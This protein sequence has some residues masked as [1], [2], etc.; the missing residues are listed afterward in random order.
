MATSSDKH[1]KPFQLG[2]TGKMIKSTDPSRLIIDRD[3]APPI[4]DNF[5][6]LKNIRYTDNG[7]KGIKGMTKINSTISNPTYFKARNIHHFSKASPS[8]SHLLVQSFNTGLNASKVLKNDTP[9]PNTG[10]FDATELHTDAGGASKGRF[11]T[12]QSGR[13]AYCNSAETMIWG[14]DKSRLSN[15]TIFDPDGSFKYDYTEKIQNTLRDPDNVASVFTTAGGDDANAVLLLHCNGADGGTIFTDDGATGHTVTAVGNA[16]TAT[17]LKKFNTAAMELNGT[18]DWCVIPDHADFDFSGT[19]WTVDMWIYP[20]DIGTASVVYSQ[21]NTGA[22]TDYIQCALETNGSLSL[23]IIAASSTVVGF[24]TTQKLTQNKWQHVA[25]SQSGSTYKI[26]INGVLAASLI[27]TNNAANYTGAVHIGN[28]NRGST[29]DLP[30]K[31]Y[32]DEIRVSNISRWTSDFTPPTSQYSANVSFN[33]Y[34]GNVLPIKAINWDISTVNTSAGSTAIFYWT[35]GAWS[36]VTNLSD[37]TASG[38]VPFAQ[39]GSMT[40]D[41]TES[42]A[43]Q[44]IIDGVLGFWCKVEITNVDT[45]TRISHVTVTEPWQK[46]QDFWDG[47]LRFASSVQKFEDST[48]KDNTTNVFDE[49]YVYEATSGGDL[50]TYMNLD[51]LT[52]ST[53]FIVVGFLERQQGLNVK[54]IPGHSNTTPSTT[55]DVNYWNGNAWTSVGSVTDGTLENDISFAKSGFVTWNAIAENTEFRISIGKKDPLYY[56]K[57]SWDQTFAALGSGLNDAVL[58]YYIAGIPVQKQVDHYAFALNAQN[59]TFLCNNRVNRRNSILIGAQDSFNAFNGKDSQVLTFGD[60]TDITAATEIFTKIVSGAVSDVVV[61]KQ[62]SL[63]LLTGTD[64][65]SWVITQISGDIGCPAPY[66]FKASP[67]GLETSPL[68]SKQVVIWQSENGIMMYDSTSIFPISDSISNYFDQSNSE[69][70]NLSTITDSY[71]FWTQVNGDHEYHWLFCSG[72]SGTTI[73][74]ELVFD[75]RRQKWYE[76]ARTNNNLQCGTQVKTTTGAH[77][78]YGMIDTGFCERLENGTAWTG[79]GTGITYELEFGDIPLEGNINVETILRFLRLIMKTKSVTTQNITVTHYLDM[80]QTGK[81]I[82]MSPSKTGYDVTMP[83]E[84]IAGYKWGSGVFH[85]LKF[86]ITTN[87]ETIGFEPLWIGGFYEANRIKVRD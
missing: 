31:G 67:I 75:M 86:S 48:Y 8:E 24:G 59:R 44:S 36:P 29:N 66:T 16:N 78:A 62:N 71:G 6:S 87:D 84:S 34:V 10:D 3:N 43:K 76:V 80:N 72:T 33:A 37:G 53:E 51:G 46:M 45:T 13:L 11:E 68:N 49:S 82:T 77:H 2:L 41:S 7:I 79:D 39:D 69:A 28:R 73:N 5:K 65:D 32:L 47:E 38:G 70:I 30:F 26:F 61:A 58:C 85:R 52:T 57:L 19:F 9:I 17:A 23:N 25:F 1:L 55:I 40:F 18:T 22:D 60:D 12:L 64:P 63:F 4:V 54:M 27:N 14:G 50:S 83:V 56:Y 21:G 42:V 81:T 35:G 15:F 20:Q 74:T